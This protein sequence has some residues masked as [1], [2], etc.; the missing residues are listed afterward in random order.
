MKNLKL[1]TYSFLFILL[2]L[3]TVLLISSNSNKYSNDNSHILEH[4]FSIIDGISDTEI[5]LGSSSALTGHASFLGTET[6]KGSL[7]YLNHINEL[8]GINGRQIKL[9]SYDD[10]YDPP[11]TILNTKKLI[12]DD[13]VFALFDY[14]GTPTSVKIMGDVKKEHVP[15]LG[16]FTGAEEL[17]TPVNPY[18]FNVRD[19]Y[20]SESEAAIFYFVDKLR[21]DKIAVF[22]QDDAF[23]ETVLTGTNLA[24]KKRGIE[25]I[26]TSKFTRGS[27]DIENAQKII[28]NSGAEAVVMVGTYSPLSK[29]IKLSTE[30]NF[31]PYFHT[32]SFIGSNAFS[33]ELINTYN[34]DNKY[35]DKIIV[36][37]VVPSP[38]E[39]NSELLIEYQY[40]LNKYY[41]NSEFNY[42]SLEGFINAKVL[43]EALKLSGK[44]LT[45]AK[46]IE[47]LESMHNFDI[48]F[49]E[50]INYYELDHQ[51]IDEIY[52][53]KLYNDSHFH[54]FNPFLN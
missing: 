10:Q 23:G 53:S 39:N 7:S 52:Y 1:F 6:I 8:G 42:V 32:V 47:S 26:I 37:Q 4:N 41:P 9:I 43:V 49:E 5:L 51:G 35:F 29:F 50:K 16:F 46:L 54:I 20:Y 2:L 17:R 28:E 24:L 21:F 44:D 27:L 45:R 48:G 14:V 22:Y 3:I 40:L 13:K 36:T 15:A 30:N 19:S 18:L 38:Y 25:P 34:I 33:N 12:H 31:T 11:Q